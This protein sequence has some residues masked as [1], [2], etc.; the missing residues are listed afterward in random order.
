MN[1]WLQYSK[2]NYT[3]IP[4]IMLGQMS[5]EGGWVGACETSDVGRLGD[6]MVVRDQ[7]AA[8]RSPSSLGRMPR[9]TC[10]SGSG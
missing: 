2:L 8:R 4:M 7:M 6:E 1:D 10:S 5:L 3:R 9:L